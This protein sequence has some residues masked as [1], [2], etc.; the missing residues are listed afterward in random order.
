MKKLLED[1][2]HIRIL[3][4][5]LGCKRTAVKM[6]YLPLQ[7]YIIFRISMVSNNKKK[8]KL[9]IIKNYNFHIKTIPCIFI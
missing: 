5:C 8:S 4:S 9:D 1:N 3:I 7:P 6:L 2:E